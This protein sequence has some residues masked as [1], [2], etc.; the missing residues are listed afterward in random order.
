MSGFVSTC[1]CQREGQT[2]REVGR[3]A[4]GTLEV[5]RADRTT[6]SADVT[7]D[8]SKG[9][10][11]RYTWS[12]AHTL[13]GGRHV[14]GGPQDRDQVGEGRQAVGDPHARRAPALQR[15]RGPEPAHRHPG[16]AGLRAVTAPDECPTGA[17][18]WGFCL[19]ARSSPVREL[20]RPR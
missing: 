7:S 16:A 9:E 20:V 2:R 15:G 13:R 19:V 3:K 18:R 1:P 17:F 8:A 12:T 5:G 11:Y 6:R 4:D 14:P 10:P